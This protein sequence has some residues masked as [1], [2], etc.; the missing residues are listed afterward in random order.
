MSDLVSILLPFYN[1]PINQARLALDS[2]CNQSYKQ[3]EIIIILDNPSNLDLK[4][5]ILEYSNND[6]RIVTIFNEQNIGLPNSLNK[7][8]DIAKGRYIARMDGDDIST[9]DRIEKQLT[10]MQNT[11]HIDLIGCNATIINEEGHIIGEY[12]K[13]KTDY[14]QKAMLRHASINLIH[15]TWF[16]KSE[17]FKICKYRNFPH[18]EDYDFMM[19]A[20]VKGYNFYNLKDKLLF[21]RISQTSLR[22]ISRK[23]AYEQYINSQLVKIQF[24]KYNK[25]K[26]YP[27]L[28]NFN[29]DEKDKIKFMATLPLINELREAFYK[30]Q[31]FIILTL[32]YKIFRIDIRPISYRIH[33]L[34]WEKILKLREL[35]IRK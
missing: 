18:C 30:R 31:W 32:S 24:K 25:E 26:I 12:T 7:G 4:K 1:E 23:Y 34:I 29:Y 20:F 10:F 5:I 33:V 2:I 8:I 14:S 9:T 6:A 11:P 19:R 35:I 27:E 22:S 21:C 16:A 3:L 13:L 17:V 15:P 28:P